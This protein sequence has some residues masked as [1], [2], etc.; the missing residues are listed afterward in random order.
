MVAVFARP[1]LPVKH[2]ILLT[3]FAALV[4]VGWEYSLMKDIQDNLKQSRWINIDLHAGE[5]STTSQAKSLPVVTLTQ[6]RGQTQPSEHRVLIISYLFGGN[7]LKKRT[8]RLFIESARR[9]GV[10][11]AIVG[12]P[13][14]SFPLPPNVSYIKVTWNDLTERVKD[15][16][17]NGTEP[18]EMRNVRN[19]YKINDFK[20]LFAY[21]FPEHIKDYEW[22]GAIDSDVVLGDLR[23]FLSNEMLSQYDIL[24]PLTERYTMGPFT[25]YRNTPI[26]NELFRFSRRPLMEIFGTKRFRIFDEKGGISYK[27]FGYNDFRSSMSG[28]VEHNYK[29]L[30]LRWHGGDIP[31]GWDGYCRGYEAG[32]LC[33]ECLLSRFSDKQQLS[34]NCFGY[35][36]NCDPEVAF[37]HYQYSKLTMEESIADDNRMQELIDQGQYRVNFFE[38]FDTWNS[39][40]HS[41]FLTGTEMLLVPPF[42]S[43]GSRTKLR[44][45]AA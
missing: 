20:P 29:Q 43:S 11:F 34:Q 10:D 24:C 7:A 38:G 31:N 45:P 40:A 23:K 32:G 22:W 39:T 4:V 33:R 1:I 35:D 44:L 30:G 2:A 21:L 14:P 36:Q 5:L 25:L 28:I 15:R 18:A 13:A 27:T 16:V 37:C 17:F 41:L 42:E 12:Y 8:T 3:C 19:Y 6:A 26:V 9:S